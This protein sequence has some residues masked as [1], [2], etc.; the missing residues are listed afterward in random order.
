MVKLETKIPAT[1]AMLAVASV[2]GIG[3]SSLTLSQNALHHVAQ[4]EQA[5]HQTFDAPTM[6]HQNS[7]TCSPDRMA[8]CSPVTVSDGS[9]NDLVLALSNMLSRRSATVQAE[10][11]TFFHTIRNL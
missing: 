10:V 3:I 4:Q 5:A 8:H 6:T 1:W 7:V 2:V 9:D 11:L